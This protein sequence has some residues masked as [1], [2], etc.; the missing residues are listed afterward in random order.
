M[1]KYKYYFKKPKSE[2]VK[3]VLRTLL[4]SGAICVAVGAS[5]YSALKFVKKYTR[6]QMYKK[7]MFYDTFYNLKKQGCI[8]IENKNHQVY[9]SLTEKGKKKA[10]WMQIDELKINKPKK[11]DKKWRIVMF[12][13]S[14]LKTLHRNAFRGKIKELGF[15][16]IQKSVWAQPYDCKDEIYLLR[17]FFGLTSYEISLIVAE[18]LDNED[19]L[20]K[21]FNLN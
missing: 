8:K 17:D 16:P 5:S 13:I 3:D 19:N 4:I 9:I 7:R 20:K 15:M 14:Q 12:D 18:E 10:N 11:W 2:I 1:S 6:K 21:L